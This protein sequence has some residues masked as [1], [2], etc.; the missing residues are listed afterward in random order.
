VTATAIP[1]LLPTASATATFLPPAK[2]TLTPSP[3]PYMPVLSAPVF[4][5][6]PQGVGWPVQAAGDLILKLK[7][8]PIVLVKVKDFQYCPFSYY[9]EKDISRATCTDLEFELKEQ[10]RQRLMDAIDQGAIRMGQFGEDMFVGGN[11]IS[12]LRYPQFTV[13]LILPEFRVIVW[14]ASERSF[15]VSQVYYPNPPQ[16]IWNLPGEL[17]QGD[18]ADVGFVQETPQLYQAVRELLPEIVYPP[19][20]LGHLLDY[21]QVVVTYDG[22]ICSYGNDIFPSFRSFIYDLLDR[23]VPVEE[24][25]P[26]NK[27]RAVFIFWV[28]GQP[29][30]LE[31]WEDERFL[32]REKIYQYI[33]HRIGKSEIIEP[34]LSA[35]LEDVLTYLNLKPDECKPPQ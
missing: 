32:Y 16:N 29:Y 3:T 14:W 17:S 15:F 1:S 28:R 12:S 30:S 10:D 7:E 13:T 5:P 2:P 4:P 11:P 33:P 34:P 20:Y 26:A 23:S 35:N 24:S 18:A 6:L 8:A 27:P 9:H 25:R 22:K 31:I 21:E 19:E